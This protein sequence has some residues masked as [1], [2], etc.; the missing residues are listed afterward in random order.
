MKTIKI[1]MHRLVLLFCA[2]LQGCVS[3]Y[4]SADYDQPIMV[5]NEL[6]FISSQT[7]N[8]TDTSFG[9]PRYG[10]DAY[11]AE[12]YVLP[13]DFS[14]D[15]VLVP[16]QVLP[17]L[18]SPRLRYNPRR[19][20]V[21]VL[22]DTEQMNKQ[23]RDGFF[24]EKYG[25]RHV[26]LHYLFTEDA[27]KSTGCELDLRSW[28]VLDETP[29]AKNPDAT[30]IRPDLSADGQTLLLYKFKVNKDIPRELASIQH[31]EYRIY[32]QCKLIAQFDF[33]ADNYD[34][35]LRVA[36][37]KQEYGPDRFNMFKNY[38]IS[39]SDLQALW[40]EGRGFEFDTWDPE[41]ELLYWIRFSTDIN[42]DQQSTGRACRLTLKTK[43]LDCVKV[44]LQRPL[45]QQLKR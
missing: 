7:Y 30:S 1:N 44:T 32:R 6:H 27:T 16:K 45:M 12:L 19:Q 24:Y 31:R 42:E 17:P 28:S 25:S 22:R 4:F 13:L 29:Y 8:H 10:T 43:Q 35:Q 39:D 18:A 3:H 36:R 5:D 26:F 14:K 37:F 15:V 40:G 20:F 9:H 2:A 11:Q 38:G 41:K 33:N 23:G 34:D 21:E